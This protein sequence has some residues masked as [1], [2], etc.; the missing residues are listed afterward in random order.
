MKYY[1]ACYVP[2]I[3]QR[4][5]EIGKLIQDFYNNIKDLIE[6]NSF[7]ADFAVVGTK[8]YLVEL[9]TFGITASP[10]LFDWKVDTNVMHNGTTPIQTLNFI[11][12]NYRTIRI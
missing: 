4:K 12:V 6:M 7:V 2:E 10:S 5:D 1:K 11:D 9:N 8:V 3:A